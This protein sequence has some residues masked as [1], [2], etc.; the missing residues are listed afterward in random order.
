ME[1][2]SWQRQPVTNHR[3]NYSSE[4]RGGGGGGEMG[5]GA[6]NSMHFMSDT[7]KFWPGCITESRSSGSVDAT[8]LQV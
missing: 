8:P 4:S 7:Y 1:T 2:P 5:N 3:S 6:F